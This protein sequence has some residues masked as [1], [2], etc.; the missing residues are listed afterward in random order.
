MEIGLLIKEIR[1]QKKIKQTSIASFLKLNQSN[2]SKLENGTRAIK[3]D[4]LINIAQYLKIPISDFFPNAVTA[5]DNK[6]LQDQ[7][8]LLNQ[9]NANKTQL[10]KMLL[11]K[12][13][14]LEQENELL[15]NSNVNTR[16]QNLNCKEN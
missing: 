7:V 10:I 16:P 1:L 14:D 2:Y 13:K 15:K 6:N 8:K 3:I 4:E 9:D 11:N 5:L 12:I